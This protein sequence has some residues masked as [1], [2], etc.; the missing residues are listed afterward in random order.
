MNRFADQVAVVTGA[1][2]GIGKAVAIRLSN[3]G[4]RIR[5]V[6]RTEANSLSAASEINT[7]RPQSAVPYAVDVSNRDEVADL[8]SRI[9]KEF[10]KVSVIVSDGGIH[11][12]RLSRRMSGQDWDIVLDTNLKGAF[13]F[14]QN[15]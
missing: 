11:R 1:G 14:I 3:E 15:F 5:V 6:S 10:G 7:L 13:H 8:C 4:R 2:R 9:V 12:D